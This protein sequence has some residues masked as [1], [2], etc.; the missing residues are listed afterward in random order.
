MKIFILRILLVIVFFY[1]LTW[2]EKLSV[3]LEKQNFWG[4]KKKMIGILCFIIWILILFSIG[5]AFDVQNWEFTEYE[6]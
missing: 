3:F 5:Y 6:Y 2:C 1:S 4:N